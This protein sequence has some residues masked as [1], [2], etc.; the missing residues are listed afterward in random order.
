MRTVTVI[1]YC[2]IAVIAIMTFLVIYYR[3]PQEVE[4]FA[5]S[6]SGSSSNFYSPSEVALGTLDYTYFDKWGPG[7]NF[8]KKNREFGNFGTIG[9]FP[10]IPLCDQSHLGTNCP[11]YTFTGQ[12]NVCHVSS[13]R[14]VNYDDLS[15]P[16][17]VNA[18]SAGRPRQCRQ[19][20][21]YKS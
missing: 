11:N 2:V 16:I 20:V 4:N 14:N 8:K 10:A 19:I 6:S 3:K 21:N 15:R 13:N 17:Y 9:K 12:Q 5:L 1:P 7:I 18:R